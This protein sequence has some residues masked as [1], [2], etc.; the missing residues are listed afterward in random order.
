MNNPTLTV[1]T[2]NVVTVKKHKAEICSLL[3]RL[4]LD[5]LCLNETRLS[6]SKTFSVTGFE[7]VRNDRNT[8]GGGVAILIRN[9]LSFTTIALPPQ[10]QHLEACLIDIQLS[11]G[12]NL[13]VC[14]LYDRPQN[15]LPL[16]FLG[17]LDAQYDFLLIAGD[18][19][20][21]SEAIGCPTTNV[22]GPDLVRVFERTDLIPLNMIDM[23]TT[24]H[25]RHLNNADSLLDWILSS[26]RMASKVDD[27][28]V[29]TENELRSDHSPV[30][31]SFRL[32]PTRDDPSQPRPIYCF[33]RADWPAYRSH[34]DVLL[35]PI[36][37]HQLIDHQ[38]I[39]ETNEAV[40]V[41]IKEAA[42]NSIPMITP[43]GPKRWW[44]FQAR[45]K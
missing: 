5:I 36:L 22:K 15:Q 21:S 4:Q 25:P 10:F 16:D 17:Y 43:R 29:D 11:N 7:V 35:G 2:A 40:I 9:S 31:A 26:Q 6:P 14:A 18:L 41:A 30:V 1:A 33:S 38:S 32:H 13:V 34:L 12:T 45:A 39:T 24:H 23:T 27:F 28:F 44:K 3:D 37:Q 20:A 8:Q 19:N 42:S